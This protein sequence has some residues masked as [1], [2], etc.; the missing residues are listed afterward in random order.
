MVL[1]RDLR[2]HSHPQGVTKLFPFADEN[3]IATAK[4][5]P[6]T[7]KRSGTLPSLGSPAW[8]FGIG[9]TPHPSFFFFLSREQVSDCLTAGTAIRER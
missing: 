4:S 8:G 2:A 6:D 5:F 1:H 7:P 3:G 9:G